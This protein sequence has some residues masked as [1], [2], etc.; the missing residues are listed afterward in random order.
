MG[1]PL[2]GVQIMIQGK[3]KY[4]DM[5]YFGSHQ[6]IAELDNGYTIH[7]HYEGGSYYERGSEFV[8]I[9]KGNDIIYRRRIPNY[10]GSRQR[11]YIHFCRG[12]IRV[13]CLEYIENAGYYVD[14]KIPH[15]VGKTCKVKGERRFPAPYT[16]CISGASVQVGAES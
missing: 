6:A 1:E 2:E 13:K 5:D 9:Y 15:D 4:F 7:M 8:D 14:I 16:A 11:E 10:Y 3:V 12:Y